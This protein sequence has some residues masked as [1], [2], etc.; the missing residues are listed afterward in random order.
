MARVIQFDRVGE[1]DVLKIVDVDLP[2]LAAERSVL[3]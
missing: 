3:R 1:P 2:A